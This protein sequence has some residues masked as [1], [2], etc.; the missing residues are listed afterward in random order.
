ML[1]VNGLCSVDAHATPLHPNCI[2]KQVVAYSPCS[3]CA[4]ASFSPAASLSASTW[5]R[6][7][8]SRRRT[9]SG[10]LPD[11][12]M[13]SSVAC[14]SRSSRSSG[15]CRAC[16]SACASAAAS[17]RLAFAS[18]ADSC[19]LRMPAFLFGADH[20]QHSHQDAQAQERDTAIMKHVT[21]L[22][23]DTACFYS[24]LGRDLAQLRHWL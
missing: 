11:S 6:S 5:P 16:S 24:S 10:P 20:H 19:S 13:P 23:K 18:A 2:R 22:H 14:Q 7:S 9:P 4:S 17:S 12:A 21:P 15:S 1:T 8:S 3:R